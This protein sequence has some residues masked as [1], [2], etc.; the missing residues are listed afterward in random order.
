MRHVYRRWG[1]RWVKIAD[2]PCKDFAGSIS[3]DAC[4]GTLDITN[5]DEN[6]LFAQFTSSDSSCIVGCS[7]TKKNQASC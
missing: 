4:G 2:G 6:Y 1:A 5:Q 3:A 7:V